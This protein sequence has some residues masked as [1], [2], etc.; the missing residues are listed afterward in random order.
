MNKVTQ[1]DNISIRALPMLAGTYTRYAYIYQWVYIIP[2]SDRRKRLKQ[3]IILYFDRGYR[4][5]QLIHRIIP[6][7]LD[8]M[9]L[10]LLKKYII[11]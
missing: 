5:H 9:S 10:F 11:Q 7:L 8:F 3:Y 4:I 1:C 6:V 2:P